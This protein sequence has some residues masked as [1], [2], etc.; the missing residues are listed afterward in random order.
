MHFSHILFSGMAE[1]FFWN[2]PKISARS[3]EL[4]QEISNP[5][6]QIWY[7]HKQLKTGSNNETS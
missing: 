6:I 3:A 7:N 2:F 4:A 5:T 1:P